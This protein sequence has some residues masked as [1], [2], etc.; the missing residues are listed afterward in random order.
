MHHEL[1][2][3]SLQVVSVEDQEV[4]EALPACR[5]DPPLG[6]GVRLRGP[7]RRLDDS[8]PS[9][10]NTSSKERENF[11]SRSRIRNLTPRSRSPTATLRACWVT[12][13][14][15]GFLVR[16][17]TWTRRDPSSIAKSTYTVRSQAVSTVKKSTAR[18]PRAW[19]LRNSL[20]DRPLRRGAGPR[21]Q[22]R[23][24]VRIAVA[25]TQTPSFRSSPRILR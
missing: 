24:I 5:S 10:R 23:R 6:E 16:P 4:V 14:E 22:R 13:A 11:E 8:G 7:D 15:S 12:Q 1:S 3:G 2:Q 19:D 20:Q 17:K 9:V 21:P 25:D 18:I